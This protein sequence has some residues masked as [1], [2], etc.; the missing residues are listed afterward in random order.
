MR[1]AQGIGAAL[2]VVALASAGWCGTAVVSHLY[3]DHRLID[4]ARAAEAQRL[5]QAAEQ[6]RQLQQQ[7]QQQA[8][9]QAK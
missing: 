2:A 4:G 5:Q 8:A 9:P 1:I 7:Q 3:Q 6:L